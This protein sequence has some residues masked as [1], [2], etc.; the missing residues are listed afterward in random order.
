VSAAGFLFPVHCFYF[1]G[2]FGLGNSTRIKSSS[3]HTLVQV[4]QVTSP[5]S[6][7][8]VVVNP[9]SHTN[10]YRVVAVLSSYLSKYDKP[11][12]LLTAWVDEASRQNSRQV[13]A[14]LSSYLSK[15]DKPK[16]LLSALFDEANRQNSRHFVKSHG[17]PSRLFQL[18]A[19]LARRECT[20][21]LP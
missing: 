3:P 20:E 8:D 18:I 9:C 12:D 16:D 14:V 10:T 2:P 6:S 5:T 7:F 21:Y 11:K 19:F 17:L 1:Y 4:V 13:V 15:Y